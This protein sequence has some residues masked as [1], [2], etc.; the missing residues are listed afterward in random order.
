MFESKNLRHLQY[1]KMSG[2][3]LSVVNTS[4]PIKLNSNF[5]KI[6]LQNSRCHVTNNFPIFDFSVLQ[7]DVCFVCVGKI[8]KYQS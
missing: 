7:V 4:Q 3:F 1:F 5:Q 8:N 6:S 2:S